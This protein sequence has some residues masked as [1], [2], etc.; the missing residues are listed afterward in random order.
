M[1]KE[2]ACQVLFRLI[3]KRRTAR[4]KPALLAGKRQ[5]ESA[6][7]SND[8]VRPIQAAA[9]RLKDLFVFRYSLGLESPG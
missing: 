9:F 6:R 5:I 2:N 3:A 1:K 8:L 4:V 7:P